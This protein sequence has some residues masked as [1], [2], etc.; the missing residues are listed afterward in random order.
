MT[1]TAEELAADQ[2]EAKARAKW[3]NS[4]GA[5]KDWIVLTQAEVATIRTALAAAE[6]RAEKAEAECA[7]LRKTQ[8]VCHCGELVSAHHMGSG[9]SPVAMEELCPYTE[10]M[11]VLTAEL[12][13]LRAD[14]EK[15][16]KVIFDAYRHVL[17]EAGEP[18]RLSED[19][20]IQ[21]GRNLATYGQSYIRSRAAIDAARKEGA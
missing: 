20:K 21:L 6:S 4:H 2:A 8:A 3:L 7:W 9:H 15:M 17:D 16:H 10:E 19:E 13:A 12:A 11:V 1:P 14:G 18:K 5:P